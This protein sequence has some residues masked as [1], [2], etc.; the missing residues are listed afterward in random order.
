MKAS[1]AK[2]LTEK[3]KINLDAIQKYMPWIY[4][5]IADA[6]RD[7]KFSVENPHLGG[8]LR[9]QPYKEVEVRMIHRKL[10]ID[11]YLVQFLGNGDFLV[12][13]G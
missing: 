4:A 2:N 7:G 1:E 9:G 10:E 6:A 11:G 12:S 5:Q 8:Q 13:W 3:A